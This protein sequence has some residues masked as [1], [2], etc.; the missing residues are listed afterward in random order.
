MVAL[1][2]TSRQGSSRRSPGVVVVPPGSPGRRL[3]ASLHTLTIFVRTILLSDRSGRDDPRPVPAERH[4]VAALELSAP[5][6]LGASV[7]AHVAAR[8]E[9]LRV[10][11][12][13]HQTRELE[14]LAEADRPRHLDVPDRRALRHP[15]I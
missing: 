1:P 11:P 10:R 5:T 3:R 7:D 4:D 6:E 2:L 12:V 15:V 13:L 8:H 9:V 14:E